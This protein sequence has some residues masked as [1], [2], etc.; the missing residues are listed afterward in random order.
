MV[1]CNGSIHYWH[2]DCVF[3]YFK[4]YKLVVLEIK[5]PNQLFIQLRNFIL[6]FVSGASSSGE[7]GSGLPVV[8]VT[9]CWQVLSSN[10]AQRTSY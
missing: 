8:P 2:C 4:I 6:K 3:I 1:F 10:V 5:N 7:C 9:V